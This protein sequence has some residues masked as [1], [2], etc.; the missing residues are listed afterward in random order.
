MRGDDAQVHGG[1]G[2]DR[3]DGG[4]GGDLLYG[5][6]GNDRLASGPGASSILRGGPGDD[7]LFADD[8]GTHLI[9]EDGKDVFFTRSRD[10]RMDGGDGD[11]KFAGSD[12]PDRVDGGAGDDLISLGGGDDVDV[13]GGPGNDSMH[14]GP[15]NDRLHGDEGADV[16]DG[17][18]GVDH[19]DGGAPGGPENSA[20]DPD[21]CTAETMVS[22]RADGLPERWR[23]EITGTS[24]TRTE[25][26]TEDA[27]WELDL[28]LRAGEP[29]AA[30]YVL[31]SGT[32]SG[33]W[34]SS[35]HTEYCSYSGS[36]GFND[37]D[38]QADL[39]LLPGELEERD[40][41]QYFF[42]FSAQENGDNTWT[43]AG[44]TH[45][46]PPLL[47]VYADTGEGELVPWDRGNPQIVGTETR[48][49]GVTVVRH[50]WVLSPVR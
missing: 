15:G 47:S 37:E 41:S 44:E 25:D 10:T 22:C 21:R 4:P 9:G 30:W 5:D 26:H 50:D 8:R 23:V 17:A 12:F 6:E 19:C 29:G 39:T 31:E 16:C 7:R 11:D 33:G 36:G 13:R 1:E 43:C 45:P 49:S 28:V 48:R 46:A 40:E 14:G 3:I 18:E 35:G 42:D 34:Q 20:S 32:A 27:S 24:T 38:W 2:D